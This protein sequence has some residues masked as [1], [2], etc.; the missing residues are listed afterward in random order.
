[1]K[2]DCDAQ[3]AYRLYVQR[4]YP[5]TRP[6][7][8]VNSCGGL[9]KMDFLGLRNLTVIDKTIQLINKRHNKE[10]TIMNEKFNSKRERKGWFQ[11]DGAGGHT[12]HFGN[13]GECFHSCL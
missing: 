12:S 11:H 5:D 13:L 4:K 8:K 6:Q 1:M 9:L 2:Y 3:E 7:I 10:F